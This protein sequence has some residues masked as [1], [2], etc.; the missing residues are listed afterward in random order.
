MHILHKNPK[1]HLQRVCTDGCYLDQYNNFFCTE[2]TVLPPVDLG[3]VSMT[4]YG[5]NLPR[6]SGECTRAFVDDVTS[7]YRQSHLRH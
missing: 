5:C 7:C 6:Q 2:T 4:F 3:Y 1:V